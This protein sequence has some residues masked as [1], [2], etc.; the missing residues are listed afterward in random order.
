VL[1][2]ELVRQPT[3]G[4]SLRDSKPSEGNAVFDNFANQIHTAKIRSTKTASW[5]GTSSNRLKHQEPSEKRLAIEEVTHEACSDHT[6][7]R[8]AL[9]DG[10]ELSCKSRIKIADVHV[11]LADVFFK[12]GAFDSYRAAQ[13]YENV[14]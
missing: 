10:S 12:R 3:R 8:Y 13:W 4:S 7:G 1:G 14:Y 6:Y 5:E 11:R 9:F 2:C